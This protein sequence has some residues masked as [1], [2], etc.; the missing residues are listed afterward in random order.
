MKKE[1]FIKY[2]N[3]IA[4]QFHLTLEE[5]FTKSKKRDV[6]D[7]RQMLYFLCM[8]RPIRISYI[9]CFMQDYNYDVSH[10]TIIH[11]YRQAKKLIDSDPDYQN[12]IKNIQAND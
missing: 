6:V 5:M 9:R 4:K 1:I 7:A 8:E 2:S 11:G 10:S 3:A 12:L